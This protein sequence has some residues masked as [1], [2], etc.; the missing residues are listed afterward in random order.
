MNYQNKQ[1]KQ[2]KQA[3]AHSY[4]TI[5]ACI[6][7]GGAFLLLLTLFLPAVKLS[8]LGYSSSRNGIGIVRAVFENIGT[9]SFQ[10]TFVDLLALGAVLLV[11]ICAVIGI[12]DTLL[13]FAKQ[14]K[15]LVVNRSQNEIG[16][17]LTF[18]IVYFVICLLYILAGLDWDFESVLTGKSMVS[19][20]TYLPVIG[21]II[22]LVVSKKIYN[23]YVKAL[24]GQVNPI[25]LSGNSYQAANAA[26]PTARNAAEASGQTQ[27]VNDLELLK[28][29]KELLD[30][31]IIT[32][33]E[34]DAKKKELL[35]A[36]HTASMQAKP[37]SKEGEGLYQIKLLMLKPNNFMYFFKVYNNLFGGDA[38]EAREVARAITKKQLP[39]VMK[40]AFSYQD[41][42]NIESELEAIGAEVELVKVKSAN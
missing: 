28:K 23:H 4:A 25:S 37:D 1:D 17:Y 12:I 42:K 21:Q 38:D 22:L 10:I 40:Q 8:L 36:E 15:I 19:T 6:R 24:K 35:G 31:Q 30:G 33:A 14:D 39:I 11:A 7:L 41:A 29:Y 26:Q 20:S 9:S 16:V 32:Q 13:S 27:K 2:D 34:F 18:N 3:I 5:L